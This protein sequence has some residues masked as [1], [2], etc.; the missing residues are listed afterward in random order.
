M[1]NL[2]VNRLF[3]QAWLALAILIILAAVISSIFR[4][5]TPW[6]KQYKGEV[7]QRLTSIIGQPVTID[8]METGW[9]WFEPVVKLKH[10][11]IKSNDQ[12]PIEIGQLFVGI[13]LLKSLWHWRIQ[14]GVLY[15]DS[16][17]LSIRKSGNQWKIDG[18]S[19]NEID[20]TE[21]N[22]SKTQQLLLWLSQQESLILKH[23][24]A[25]THLQDGALIPINNLNLSIVNKGGYYKIKGEAS[26]LQTN[27]TKFEILGHID[28]DPTELDQTKGQLY[29]SVKKFLPAQWQSILPNSLVQIEGG[30]GDIELWADLNKGT[31]TNVQAHVKFKRLAWKLINQTKSELIQSFYANLGW[32]PE[33]MGWKFQADHVKFRAAGVKWPENQYLVRFN[34]EQ[35]TYQVFVK[36]LL[37]ESLVNQAI[38]W[39]DS[40]YQILQLKPHGVLTD[41][42]LLFKQNQVLYFLT[43]FSNLGWS[44]NPTIPAVENISGVLN[45]QP[46]EGR[47][48]LDSENSQIEVNGY[49]AQ[50]VDI[51]NGAL[52][53]KR[54][55]NGLRV[56]IDRFVLSQPD[57]T[58]SANGSIDEVTR[59]SLGHIRFE[60]DFTG[61]NLQK[62]IAFLPKHRMKP[63][64]FMWL[65]NDVKRLGQA[66]GR[67]LVNGMAKDFPFDNNQGEFSIQSHVLGGDLLITPKWQ[68]LKNLGGYIRLHNRN[69][70][71]DVLEGYVKDVPINQLNLRID[72]I[73]KDRET[74]LLHTIVQGSAQQ[75]LNFIL[76]SPLRD[77][78]NALKMLTIKGILSINLRLEIPLYPENDDN[79]A[80]GEI[81]FKNN[82]VQ[83]HHQLGNLSLDHLKGNLS[84]N[85][86]E[87]VDS[88]LLARAFGYPLNIRVKSEILPQPLTKISIEGETSIESLKRKVDMPIFSILQGRIAA[89]ALIK[90][91]DNPNDL[92]NVVF[93][94]DL[95]GLAVNLPQ[96]LGKNYK[97]KVPL[98]VNL[99]FNPKK[100][101]RLRTKLANRL[102]ADIMF[103][104]K[105]GVFSLDS[106]QIQLGD[107]LA[108]VQKRPGLGLVGKLKGLDIEAWRKVV[109]QFA[110]VNSQYS[111]LHKLSYIDLKLVHFD[112]MHQKLDNLSIFAKKMPDNDWSILLKQLNINADLLYHASTNTLT[113]F[114]KRLHMEKITGSPVGASSAAN[115]NPDEIPNLNLRIDN[116][117]I[118]QLMIGNVT[119]KSHSTPEQWKIDY[120]RVD[121]PY[122]QINIEGDWN[123]KN[124]KHQT[125]L[126]SRM[127]LKD[128]A[129]SLKYW[130]ISPAVDAKKGYMEFRGGWNGRLYDFSLSNLNGT[131]YMQLKNGRI[132]HLS[133]ETEEKLGLGKLLSILSLQTIPRRLK[134]DFSDLSN[135]GYSFDVYKGNFN[136][137]RGIMTTS[138]SYIDGPVAYADMKGDLDLVHNLY[139][140]N[141]RISPHITA[142]LPVVAT[143]AGGP[144]AGLAAWVANK[145]INQSMQKITGYTYKVSGPWDNPIVQQLTIEKQTND[146]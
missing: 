129:K 46:D 65:N 105:N 122:Y 115:S 85:E 38:E 5:L 83:I 91:T 43:R 127:N 82:T 119:L 143:I 87:I 2:W 117:S 95:R 8:S 18:L 73:G 109:K 100:A 80:R 89:K 64:L 42:Q 81:L 146:T 47:L 133:P 93:H 54:I 130:S 108:V 53:W 56:S 30:K 17:D 71:I 62:W 126:Q 58:L 124:N 79:L 3:K 136:I 29:F 16:L 110:T 41:T 118:G 104:Q 86:S 69:L 132:T 102:S 44:G 97:D 24:S 72:D 121:S 103:Q 134:L 32:Q 50:S 1:K 84:F 76:N 7:E 36:S 68:L 145:I 10:V 142:S 112:W 33:K 39:P 22:E 131:M 28:F 15:I 113:G 13:N 138:K 40:F 48:E 141:L 52:D 67:V 128:L 74:L 20:A 137:K 51:L 94:S 49:P 55:S 14:P 31:L 12:R 9:Y 99:D 4:S 37:V 59:D 35:N 25:H 6:A 11:S 77:K 107:S 78:L 92:D 125:T 21:I 114:V 57:L 123:K 88:T 140:L 19:S 120:C 63:K 66:T 98:L 106:G 75:M 139:D 111:I 26:L 34:K 23:V 61:K 101:F 45:W 90:I 135:E 70:E 27:A 96:P 60:M 144:I 116:L